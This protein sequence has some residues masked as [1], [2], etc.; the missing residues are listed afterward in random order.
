MAKALQSQK[1]IKKISAIKQNTLD[2][3]CFYCHSDG[4]PITNMEIINWKPLF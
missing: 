2:P 1:S 3:Y 4:F